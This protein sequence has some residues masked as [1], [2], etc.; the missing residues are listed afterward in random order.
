[1]GVF[2]EPARRADD[3]SRL[4]PCE[5]FCEDQAVAWLPRAV[6]GQERRSFANT[7]WSAT[8]VAA[9]L[10]GLVL[11]QTAFAPVA[12]A[13]DRIDLNPRAAQAFEA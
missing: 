8:L 9:L 3:V 12:A 4:V 5:T 2:P 10:A 13:H 6:R 7:R 1:M 11:P